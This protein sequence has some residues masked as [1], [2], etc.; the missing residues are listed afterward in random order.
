MRDNFGDARATKALKSK[1]TTTVK[2]EDEVNGNG[3]WHKGVIEDNIGASREQ[4]QR[5]TT[6]MQTDK[7]AAP[8]E[9]ET[10]SCRGQEQL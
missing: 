10:G 6:P 3:G 2:I 1:K 9:G 8:T 5:K 7:E 4:G